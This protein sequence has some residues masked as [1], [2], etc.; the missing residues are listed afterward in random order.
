MKRQLVIVG[1]GFAGVWAAAAAA[2][3]RRVG[4]T[5][6]QLEIAVIT[7]EPDLVV[8]PRLYEA[9][10][11]ATRVPLAA[12]LDKIGVSL[13][14]GRVSGI[15]GQT[16]TIVI[17]DEH[18][19][20]DGVVLAAGS[21][22]PLPGLPGASRIAH[23]IDTF[24]RARAFRSALSARRRQGS[25]QVTVVGAGLTGLELAAELASEPDIA[26][27][28]IDTGAVGRGFNGDARDALVEA[29]HLLGVEVHE[30]TRVDAIDEHSTLTT[31][32]GRLGH[33]LV[34]WCGGLRANP[35]T[36]TLLAARDDLGRLEVDASLRVRGTDSVWAAGD[37]A[38]T[39]PDGVH[40]APMSCQFALPTGR[41]AGHNAAAQLTGGVV[42]PFA[43][44]RY[45]TCVDLGSAGALFT[46]GWDRT[47]VAAGAEGKAVK[48]HINQTA[49]VPPTDPDE[50]LAAAAP[51]APA[52][53]L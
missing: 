25:C 17:N 5:R 9:E 39:R 10:L 30:R 26:V 43:L 44:D 14:V 13:E 46:A 21:A 23:R 31:S 38:R 18:R 16:A 12:R 24:D 36:S 32:A 42:V 22:S 48:R 7:A 35:L 29:L 33:D 15:D 52:P 11:E 19:P 8:R 1:G 49:I 51:D 4:R 34:V 37:V 45:V 40:V 3:Q 53:W 6:A 20:F 2:A 28:L 50:L 47:P 27:K 41:V